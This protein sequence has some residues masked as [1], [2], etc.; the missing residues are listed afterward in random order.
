MIKE[1][2]K[3]T[4]EWDNEGYKVWDSPY[5]GPW[6]DTLLT[7]INQCSAMIH[8][9]SQYGGASFIKINSKL[10]PLIES[11]YYY[12]SE[13]K[14]LAG[15]Y[16]I[17]IDNDIEDN[18]MFVY[19]RLLK[20]EVEFVPEFISPLYDGDFWTF[21]FVDARMIPKEKV[22]EYKKGLCTC[23]TIKNYEN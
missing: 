11:V 5:T 22:E 19:H 4:I 3:F 16:I 9:S 1:N 14:T 21:T 17:E 2:C 18:L 6:T 20:N 8:K 15:R 10:L 12:N 7:K 13:E 23:I